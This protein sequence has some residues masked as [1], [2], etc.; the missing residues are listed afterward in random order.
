[1]TG[2]YIIHSDTLQRYYIGATYENIES[3]LKNHNNGSYGKTCFTAKAFDWSLVIFITTENYAHAIR[4]E[5]KIKSM[6]SSKYITNLTKYPE[7]IAQLVSMKFLF[8]N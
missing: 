4:I 1:M 7:L 6:K 5:R 2:C 8:V 3:R